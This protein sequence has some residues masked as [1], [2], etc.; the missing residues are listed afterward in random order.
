MFI[1]PQLSCDCGLVRE[2]QDAAAATSRTITI[3]REHTRPQI[4]TTIRDRTCPRRQQPSARRAHMPADHNHHWGTHA[5]V[6]GTTLTWAHTHATI[7]R[8]THRTHPDPR[9]S[10]AAIPSRVKSLAVRERLTADTVGRLHGEKGKGRP[11]WDGMV[12]VARGLLRV[13]PDGDRAWGKIV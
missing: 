13:A 10:R 6:P 3:A 4:A 7:I 11:H 12:L 9:H 5:C 1:A 2:V 8:C